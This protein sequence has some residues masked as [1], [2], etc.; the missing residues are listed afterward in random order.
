HEVTETVTA[1]R[2]LERTQQ[3]L[4]LATEMAN[5]QVYDVDYQ[6]RTIVSSG[7]AL[8]PLIEAEEKS[9]ADAVFTGDT[10]RFIDPRDRDRV[11]EAGRRFH[12]A[13]AAYDVEYRV[14]RDNGEEFWIAEMMQAIRGE[15][16]KI[17]RMVG[18]MQNITAR[19]LAE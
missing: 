9:V 10:G 11:A 6:R 7:K 14:L 15:D 13:G 16:G 17:R 4:L 5:L 1:M 12:E 18:A 3:R 8:F 19:K 2:S